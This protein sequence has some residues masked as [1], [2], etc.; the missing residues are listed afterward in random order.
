VTG[1]PELCIGLWSPV[2]GGRAG[3]SVFLVEKLGKWKFTVS[4]ETMRGWSTERAS[5][6]ETLRRR[7]YLKKDNNVLIKRRRGEEKMSCF[8]GIKEAG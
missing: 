8:M 5:G 3:F 7:G 6:G 4:R 2:R 1:G